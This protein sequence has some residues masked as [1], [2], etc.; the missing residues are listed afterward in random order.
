MDVEAED[1][2]QLPEADEARKRRPLQI[3]ERAW[4][5]DATWQKTHCLVLLKGR[6]LLWLFKSLNFLPSPLVNLYME[7]Y[8]VHRIL[9]R[10][11]HKQQRLNIASLG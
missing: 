8:A 4:P 9:H 7:K 1:R 10:S 3:P 6:K 11:L 5:W 2:W